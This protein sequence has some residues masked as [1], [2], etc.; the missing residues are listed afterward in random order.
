MY[1][2]RTIENIIQSATKHFPAPFA[3]IDMGDDGMP[4]VVLELTSGFD[5][6]FEI[7]HYED[8]KV[9]GFNRPYRGFLGLTSDGIYEGSSGA[10]DSGF[11]TASI[12]KD[13]YREKALGYSVS[14]NGGTVSYHIGDSEATESEF[15]EFLERMWTHARENEAVWHDFTSENIASVFN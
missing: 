3:L 2:P 7:L 10:A 5:G 13:V 4:K 14:G 15:G 11:Y 1:L 9:Y 12:K 8:G 6:A